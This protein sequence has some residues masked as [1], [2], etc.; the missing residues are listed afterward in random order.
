MIYGSNASRLHSWNRPFFLTWNCDGFTDGINLFY[1]LKGWNLSRKSA[2]NQVKSKITYSIIF[3]VFKSFIIFSFQWQMFF[4]YCLYVNSYGEQMMASCDIHMDKL[5]G[6]QFKWT[7]WSS[8]RLTDF[9]FLFVWVELSCGKIVACGVSVIVSIIALMMSCRRILA[10]NVL[11]S[12][13]SGSQWLQWPK[14]WG[15]NTKIREKWHFKVP[16]SSL[17]KVCELQWVCGR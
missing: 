7:L 14:F 10:V 15:W 12:V 16:G 6:V 17:A 9:Y 1:E 8:L 13:S 4:I 3:I 11:S 5:E 2:V